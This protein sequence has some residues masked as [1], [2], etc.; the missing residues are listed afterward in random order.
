MKVSVEEL[1]GVERRLTV[2]LEAK[3]V[4]KTINKLYNQLKGT[5]KIKGF[6]P[7]KVPRPILERYY[8]DR[9]AGEASQNLIGTSYSEALSESG[10]EPIAQPDFDFQAPMQ[11]QDFTYQITFD[12]KP[13]FELETE[14]YQGFEIKEPKF[15]ANDEELT[16]R[17]EQLRERQAMLVPLEEE[18][19]AEI[20]DVVVVDY[21]T[22]EG[23]EPVEGGTAENADIDLGSGNVQQEI[24]VA[25]VKASV[26]DTVETTVHF[27]DDTP[28]KAMAGK[29]IRFVLTVK[30]LKKKMLPE[31]DDDFARGIGAEFDDLQALKDR[32]QTDLEEMQEQQKDQE[33]RRQIL[34]HIRDLGE[35]D[36]PASLVAQEVEEMVEDFKRRLQQSGMDPEMAGLDD[37]KLAED[38]QIQAEKKVR[39]GIVLGKISDLEEVEVSQEDLDAEFETMAQRTGQ[40]AE[41]LK[42][43]YNKNNAMPS[44]TSRIME[45]KTLQAIKAGAIIKEVNPEELAGETQTEADEQGDES[46]S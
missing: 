46:T 40:P 20:G 14:A 1:S 44:L 41:V 9:V 21:E 18:R 17:L 34:D 32:L 33:V 8:G 24:E 11:G 28:N 10:L 31:L 38:F 12:V 26:G 25:L 22:F 27:D 35:F 42:D 13:E 15:E 2:E 19:P 30:G 5:A 45:E 23:D 36:L 29:D 43:I 6:R 39:A 37:S 4:D 3:E 16:Q 7:G